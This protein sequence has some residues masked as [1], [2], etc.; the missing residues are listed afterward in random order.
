MSTKKRKE[1]SFPPPPGLFRPSFS[2]AACCLSDVLTVTMTPPPRSPINPSSRKL[3]TTPFTFPARLRSAAMLDEFQRYLPSEGKTKFTHSL[4]F[5]NM[6]LPSN[7]PKSPRENLAMTHAHLGLSKS[8]FE[9]MSKLPLIFSS[10]L[11]S[12]EGTDLHTS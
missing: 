7:F 1:R 4:T 8:N 5:K 11:F 10:A 12:Q 3:S 2:R 6:D 9:S